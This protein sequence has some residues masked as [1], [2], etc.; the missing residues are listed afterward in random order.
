VEFFR[1]FFSFSDGDTA[2]GY[3]GYE[4]WEYGVAFRLG[5]RYTYNGLRKVIKMLGNNLF[6][7]CHRGVLGI[8]RFH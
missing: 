6:F 3:W 4:R 1:Y 7:H 8:V 2:L 5:W